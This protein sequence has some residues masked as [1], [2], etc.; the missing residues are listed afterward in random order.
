[1]HGVRIL[2]RGIQEI[3]VSDHALPSCRQRVL[4]F[5]NNLRHRVDLAQPHA[6]QVYYLAAFIVRYHNRVETL[7]V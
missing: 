4:V 3:A 7:V 6:S 1:M 2:I 5:V